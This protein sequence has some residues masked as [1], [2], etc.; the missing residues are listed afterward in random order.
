MIFK[1]Y[2]TRQ[3]GLWPPVFLPYGGR[4]MQMTESL[5]KNHE[6]R[7]LYSRGKSAVSPYFAVYTRTNRL[8]VNRLGVTVGTKVGKAVQRN[9]VR[10]RIREIYRLNEH[11]LVKGRDIVIV[12]RVRARYAEYRELERDMLNLL[13]RLGLLSGERT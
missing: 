5:K 10:R 8:G 9:R 13:S 4:L 1:G 2:D 3:G 7:R 12:A 11:R 6:F